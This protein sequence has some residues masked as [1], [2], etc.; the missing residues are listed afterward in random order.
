MKEKFIYHITINLTANQF[1]LVIQKYPLLKEG[2]KTVFF[3]KGIGG[4]VRL[5]K[6]ELMCL[7][8]YGRTYSL[9]NLQYS[10]YC[11]DSTLK[12]AKQILIDTINFKVREIEK[13]LKNALKLI[14]KPIKERIC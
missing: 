14:N 9:E 3:D 11:D 7:Q 8:S 13:Q 1:N 4:Q 12:K 2:D 6:S 10:L 5:F